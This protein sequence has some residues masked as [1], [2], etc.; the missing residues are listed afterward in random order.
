METIPGV[1][2]VR[3]FGERRYAMRLWM[4]PVKLA[5]HCLT[6]ADVQAS[7]DSQNVDLPSGRLE[8]ATNEL[9]LRTLGRLST[10][11]EF[12]NLII[13]RGNGR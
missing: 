11:E 6:P 2:S 9:S 5:V 1:S 13:K 3:I 7:L 4:Y 10:P 12:E 8:G